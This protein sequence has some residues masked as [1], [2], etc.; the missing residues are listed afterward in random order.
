[1]NEIENREAYL[2]SKEERL[3]RAQRA[4]G[5]RIYTEIAERNRDHRLVEFCEL[6]TAE[7]LLGEKVP[8]LREELHLP[9]RLRS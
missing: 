4:R 8:E 6:Q 2:T 1:M 9:L 5:W 3:I 7:T